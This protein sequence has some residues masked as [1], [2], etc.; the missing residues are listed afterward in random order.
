MRFFLICLLLFS[1]A[2]ASSDTTEK[3]TK[4]AIEFLGVDPGFMI[5]YSARLV[6]QKITDQLRMSARF[7]GKLLGVDGGKSNDSNALSSFYSFMGVPG[8]SFSAG[9]NYR[10]FV[11]GKTIQN[12]TPY[13]ELATWSSM[14]IIDYWSYGCQISY[15]PISKLSKICFADSL[16]DPAIHNGKIKGGQF[17]YFKKSTGI[18]LMPMVSWE[19]SPIREKRHEFAYTR[20]DLGLPICITDPSVG[21]WNELYY[22]RFINFDFGFGMIRHL[23]QPTAIGVFE[24]GQ[25]YNSGKLIQIVNPG[26]MDFW[27]FMVRLDVGISFDF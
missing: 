24:D 14:E 19:R 7:Q 3:A 26:F 12:N 18:F 8:Y 17:Q 20:I 23:W 21:L 16:P 10:F 2:L 11:G 4:L 5:G 15:E 9:I 22:A 27:S 1:S 13:I 25:G 6:D